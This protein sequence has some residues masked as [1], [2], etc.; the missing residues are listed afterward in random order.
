MKTA[1]TAASL[2][3][4]L[5]LMIFLLAIHRVPEEVSEKTKYY[6]YC[7][8]LTLLGLLTDSA[9]YFLDGS[10]ISTFILVVINYFSYAILDWLI[11]CFGF[12]I[13]VLIREKQKDATMKLSCFVALLCAADSIFIFAGF[14]TG[15][16]VKIVDN[17]AVSG[18]LNHFILVSPALCLISM[19]MYLLAKIKV[20]GGRTVLILSSYLFIPFIA[21]FLNLIIPD[22]AP[23]Y[24]SSAL[25][26]AI[27]FVM[28]QSKVIAET[29][30]RANIYS[31]LSERDVLT[32]LKNRRAYEKALLNLSSD[33]DEGIVFCDVNSLKYVNDT[34]GHEAGDRLIRRFADILKSFFANA[35]ICRIGGDEFV[36]IL[37]NIGPG[38]KEKMAEFERIMKENGRIASFGYASGSVFEIKRIVEAAEQM[39]YESKKQYYSETGRDRRSR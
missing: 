1:T 8:W 38:F 34:E 12:Y 2:V 20:L 6:R 33:G 9:A 37:E 3:S 29:K 27:I 24:V 23:G 5:F 15:D 31:D 18:E 13:F 22:F 25:A 7:L 11:A 26:M 32:Q 35:D 17:R 19:L 28:L 21:A 30:V 39:M 36:V 4:A 14:I 10:N 16:I